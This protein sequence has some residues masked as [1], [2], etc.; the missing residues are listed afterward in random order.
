MSSKFK[1]FIKNDFI[2]GFFHGSIAHFKLLGKIFKPTIQIFD[3][4]RKSKLYKFGFLAGLM[5][6]KLTISH[7][8]KKKEKEK[9]K[10]LD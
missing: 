8:K 9:S 1:T 5:S 3:E 6:L 10:E 2:V 7:S 4:K